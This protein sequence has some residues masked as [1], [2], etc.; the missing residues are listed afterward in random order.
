MST[1]IMSTLIWMSFL[2]RLNHKQTNK[3]T[4]SPMKRFSVFV[5]S[6]MEN[7]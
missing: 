7:L 4:D 2:G 6:K 5:L 3:L 1:L